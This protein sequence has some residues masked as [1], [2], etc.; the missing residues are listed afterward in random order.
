MNRHT[1]FNTPII[2]PLCQLFS[3]LL[4][5]LAGWKVEGKRP[6]IPKYVLIA[7]PHTSNWDFYYLILMAFYYRMPICW[8]GKDSLFHGWRG[9]FM[10]WLGG[11]P[12]NRS[13]ASNLVNDTVAAFRQTDSMTIAIPP[14]GTRGQVTYWKSGFYHIA[15]GADVPIVLGYLDFGRKCG[16]L[17]PVFWPTGDFDTDLKEIK[18]FYGPIQG[19]HRQNFSG[20][21]VKSR[22]DND[23][24]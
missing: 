7:A 4:L 15:R 9:P 14:E 24:Q 11:I 18:A 17:G 3:R 21:A 1:I 8:M 22:Q 10:R 16:G 12:V 19:K 23:K 13:S 6:D 20:D 2:T 5:S